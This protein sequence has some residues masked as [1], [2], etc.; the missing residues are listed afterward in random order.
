MY[1]GNAIHL[2]TNDFVM[3]TLDPVLAPQLKL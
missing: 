3:K 1:L 2:K